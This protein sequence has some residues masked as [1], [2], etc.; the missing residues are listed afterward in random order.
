[1]LQKRKNTLVISGIIL[2]FLTLVSIIVLLFVTNNK[3]SRV[4]SNLDEKEY[5]Y[6]I[7]KSNDANNTV[8]G[9]AD[10]GGRRHELKMVYDANDGLSKIFYVIEDKYTSNTEAKYQNNISQID[11]ERYLNEHGISKKE[12]ETSFSVID[13][14]VSKIAIYVKASTMD[15]AMGDIFLLKGEELWEMKNNGKNAAYEIYTSKG[16]SCKNNS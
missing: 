13:E 9:R 11:F 10:V 1:M 6:I 3:S 7:C 8:F 2:L 15:D 5:T 14:N 16:F 12:V 4:S